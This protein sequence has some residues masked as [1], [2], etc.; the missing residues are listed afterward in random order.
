MTSYTTP[1]RAGD[2]P[3]I[4]LRCELPTWTAVQRADGFTADSPT[5]D[6]DGI[7]INAPDPEELVERVRAFERMVALVS[8]RGGRL[9]VGRPLG[10]VDLVAAATEVVPA[11]APPKLQVV[12]TPKVAAA[13]ATDV[14][15]KARTLGFSGQPC[16]TCGS[17]NTRNAGTCLVC[18]DC[19]ATS[20]CS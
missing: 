10:G 3:L 12:E 13:A 16:T 14:Y 1:L 19:G 7:S 15:A 8:G 20:G 2:D 17:P 6:I 18:T 5:R 11:P 4:W 9:P